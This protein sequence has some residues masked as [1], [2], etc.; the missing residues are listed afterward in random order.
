[1]SNVA[2]TTLKHYNSMSK[3]SLML[4]DTT[5]CCTCF[6][7]IITSKV[8]SCFVKTQSEEWSE[9]YTLHPKASWNNGNKRD[10]HFDTKHRAVLD[11]LDTVTNFQHNQMCI[12]TLNLCFWAT[13]VLASS[14]TRGGE[15]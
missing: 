8:L 10:N 5:L 9:T 15:K 13:R 11:K 6:W 3:E 2:N 1:M 14:T 7:S 4:K 12:I